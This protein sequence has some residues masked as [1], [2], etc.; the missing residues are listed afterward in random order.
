MISSH[1]V[2]FCENIFK[3]SNEHITIATPFY[4]RL[5]PVFVD[6]STSA[7]PNDIEDDLAN[8]TSPG[9]WKFTATSVKKKQHNIRSAASEEKVEAKFLSR[10]D[11][12]HRHYHQW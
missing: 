7:Q 8:W 2:V 4:V 6:N 9:E 10:H 11:N 5:D 12:N 1:D 3:V